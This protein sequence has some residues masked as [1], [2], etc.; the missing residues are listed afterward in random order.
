MSDLL[1]DDRI[2]VLGY[3][4]QHIRRDHSDGADAAKTI[5]SR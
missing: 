3:D 2:V 4:V 5:F 1:S